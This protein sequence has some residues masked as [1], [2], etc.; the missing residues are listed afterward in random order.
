[1]KYYGCTDCQ[2]YWDNYSEIF[3]SS[4]N[5]TREPKP[6]NLDDIMDDEADCEFNPPKKERQE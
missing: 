4:P 1:M 2:Y 6:A 5:C 3:G